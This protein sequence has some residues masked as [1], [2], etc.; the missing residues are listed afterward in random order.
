M[1][2]L[3]LLL[4]TPQA[5]DEAPAPARGVVDDKAPEV[6]APPPVS[7]ITFLAGQRHF[8]KG[9]WKAAY[10]AFSTALKSAKG[11]DERAG[12]LWLLELAVRSRGRTAPVMRRPMA[13]D[14]G[15][16]ERNVR[17][18]VIQLRA[19]LRFDPSNPDL[20]R[21]MGEAL[22][23]LPEGLK[24]ARSVLRPLAVVNRLDAWQW[25]ALSSLQRMTKATHLD[26]VASR[27]RCLAAG[28]EERLCEDF[29]SWR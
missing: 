13:K 20:R 6:A 29:C 22:A 15:P 16:R 14:V 1:F 4:L 17:N 10:E 5:F 3:T 19:W 28:G 8:E 21:F 9:E 2:L 23:C 7:Q 27:K 12:Q 25:A 18:A 24:E 26:A 11:A